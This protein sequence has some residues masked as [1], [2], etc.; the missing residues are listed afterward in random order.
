[1]G[2]A[3]AR[4]RCLNG[5]ILHEDIDVLYCINPVSVPIDNL[6]LGR[7]TSQTPALCR[8]QQGEVFCPTEDSVDVLIG[9]C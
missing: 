1:M 6:V 8:R 9:I 3:R 2:Q 7:R 4:A 5:N